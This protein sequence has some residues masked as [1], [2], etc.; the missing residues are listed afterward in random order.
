MRSGKTW[1]RNLLTLCHVW[2]GRAKGRHIHLRLCEHEHGSTLA[3][4]Q[5]LVGCLWSSLP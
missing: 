5:G 3:E 2:T 4:N 1:R